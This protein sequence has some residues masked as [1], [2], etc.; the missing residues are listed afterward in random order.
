MSRVANS[1]ISLWQFLKWG[2]YSS[3]TRKSGFESE[4]IALSRFAE[5]QTLHNGVMCYGFLKNI[6]LLVY[7]KIPIASLWHITRLNNN[8]WAKLAEY[9][10]QKHWKN[11]HKFE[12][13]HILQFFYRE[14]SH[15]YTPFPLIFYSNL[16]LGIIVIKVQIFIACHWHYIICSSWFSAVIFRPDIND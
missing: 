13:L 12:V 16:N 11:S 15:T 8:I 3:K 1:Y 6:L 14:F 2:F 10:F 7:C 4:S 9:H 5:S